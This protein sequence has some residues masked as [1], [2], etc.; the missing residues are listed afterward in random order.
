MKKL[1]ILV[2]PTN[3]RVIVRELAPKIRDSLDKIRPGDH[4]EI[5]FEK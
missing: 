1:A 5:E 3:R 4:V 2:L